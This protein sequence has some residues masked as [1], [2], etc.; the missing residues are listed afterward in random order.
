[1]RSL[2]AFALTALLL[3]TVALVNGPL[4][5][6]DSPLKCGTLDGKIVCADKKSEAADKIHGDLMKKLGG[7]KRDCRFF[8]KGAN[9]DAFCPTGIKNCQTDSTGG[10]ICCCKKND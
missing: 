6:K 4:S 9:L 2:I 3:G 8:A 7:K 10:G 1:M 5:A